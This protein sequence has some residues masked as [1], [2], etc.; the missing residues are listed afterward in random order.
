MKITS[1]NSNYNFTARITRNWD[2]VGELSQKE[3]V[4]TYNSAIKSIA[5]KRDQA[6][7]LDEFMS[8]KEVKP[9]LK[10]LPKQDMVN[11]NQGYYASS[12]ETDEET[13]TLEYIAR[14]DSSHDKIFYT[15]INPNPNFLEFRE[16]RTSEGK[17]NKKGIT[18]WLKQ[19]G[20]FFI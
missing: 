17:L 9:L 6:L 1:I 5:E 15:T 14:E 7:E 13:P 18:E 4:N 8:S 20:E 3:V 19:L 10:K 16:V 12:D 2:G 11:I